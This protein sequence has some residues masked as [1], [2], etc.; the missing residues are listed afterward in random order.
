MPE[1]LLKFA[2][3]P[4]AGPPKRSADERARD[5]GEIYADFP[6]PAA[7]AQSARCSQCGV[8]FCQNAC[9]L[10]N[11]IPDWLRLA[12]EGRL[13]EAYDLSAA[14]STLPEVCGRIC[15]QDRLCEGSCVVEQA[16]FGTVTIGAVERFL[17][18]T[19]WE[20]GWVAPVRPRARKAQS[21]GIVGSGPA[22]L[23]AAERLR[24]AGYAVTIYDR[25]D[26]AGG[27]LIYGIP[28]FKLEKSVVERRTARL[29]EG[30]IA[31]ELNC[32]VGRDVTLDELRGRHDAVL[33][34]TGVYAARSLERGAGVVPALDYLIAS[35]R[36]GLGDAVAAFADGRLD[37][38]GKRVLVLGGGDTAMDC[39]RTAVRQGAAEVTCL[40]RRDRANMPGSAREVAHAEEEGVRFEWLTAPLAT[41]E[42]G[43]VEVRRM[44]LGAPDRGGRRAPEP[45]DGPVD[46]AAELMRADL[47]IGALGFD[48][49]DL[50]ELWEAPDLSRSPHGALRIDRKSFETTLPGVFA[51]GDIV[52][53]ASLVV[54]AVRDGIDAAQAMDKWLAARAT[55]PA[56]VL[57]ATE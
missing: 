30:G 18:E 42:D 50:P 19:A 1:A 10:H 56:L 26:R 2:V 9:P 6:V 57:A 25:H 17:T 7:E 12:A 13:R 22:G 41:V 4:H 20:K 35:N 31:F 54:W 14:T 11:D 55:T 23:T 39:L 52:R 36:T 45:V 49:E 53:G 32:E 37:A 3:T 33:V 34:A 46:G 8:P 15:P 38:R 43:A 51:A 5:F 21:V 27:L 40:Y 47:V 16:G 24:E 48:A 28:G 29:A 44:R